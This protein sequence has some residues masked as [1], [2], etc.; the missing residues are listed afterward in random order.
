[1]KRASDSGWLITPST[2]E[3]VLAGMAIRM[4]LCVILYCSAAIAASPS[5]KLDT[6]KRLLEEERG[7]ETTVINLVNQALESE[8]SARAYN[9]RGIAFSNLGNHTQAI[10]DYTQ[11]IKLDPAYAKAYYNR[12]QSYI[13]TK[14]SDLA[15]LDLDQ[16]LR[17]KPDYSK[18]FIARSRALM[19]M[20][21]TADAV[22]AITKAVELL[23][24]DPE[25]LYARSLLYARIGN[26]QKAETDCLGS[27]RIQESWEGHL[28]C[29][30]VYANSKEY[31]K[32]DYSYSRVI[33]LDNSSIDAYSGRALAR[34]GLGNYSGALSDLDIAIKASPSTVE[35][36]VYRGYALKG[37][38][39]PR[40]ACSDWNAYLKLRTPENDPF[41]EIINTVKSECESN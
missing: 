13:D 28:A 23:P 27:L 24:Q 41:P 17:V 14:R 6:A 32:A 39:K 37:L 25:P 11:A 2:G 40:E 19:E 26:S 35:S 22:V 3:A 20:G 15:L 16:A 30:V 9:Y 34:L 10:L 7:Q 8:V 33:A 29:A 5:E 38:D 1:M 12:A 36:Y 4:C 21:K 31:E 18:V